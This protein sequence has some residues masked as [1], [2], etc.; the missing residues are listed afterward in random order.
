MN[1][2]YFMLVIAVVAVWK[3]EGLHEGYNA[4]FK[5]VGRLYDGDASLVRL[6]E[7]SVMVVG[8]GGVGSWV[9][10]A[11]ARSGVGKITLVDGDDVCQSNVNRQLHAV[12]STIGQMKVDVLKQRLVDINPDAE[13]TTVCD[14]VTQSNIE[15]IITDSYNVVCECVDGVKDKAWIL[16]ACAR[17]AVPVVSVGGVGDLRDPCTLVVSDFARSEGDLL[18]QKTRKLLRR[19]YGFPSGRVGKRPNKRWRIPVVHTMPISEKRGVS[20]DESDSS[21]GFR[22][23]DTVLGNVS[24]VTGTAGFIMAAHVVQGIAMD[25]LESPVLPENLENGKVTVGVSQESSSM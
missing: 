2:F 21:G 17:L 22:Q 25:E 8:I 5:N 12:T 7:S 11:L 13:V 16:N 14:F 19:E 6:L 3:V 23:C 20:T 24:F 1:L 4:R 10:E 18:V 9:A 15:R